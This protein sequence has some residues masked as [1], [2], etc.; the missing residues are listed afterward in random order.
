MTEKPLLMYEV[1]KEGSEILINLEK[2]LTY[3]YD[4]EEGDTDDDDFFN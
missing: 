2:E 4:E 3:D 1:K